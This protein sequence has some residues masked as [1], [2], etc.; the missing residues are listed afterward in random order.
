MDI[1]PPRFIVPSCLTRVQGTT[2]LSPIFTAAEA[3]AW[4]VYTEGSCHKTGEIR[5]QK[6]HAHPLSFAQEL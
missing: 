5:E 4:P 1:E 2:P 3:T 6:A